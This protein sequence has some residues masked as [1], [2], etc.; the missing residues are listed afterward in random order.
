MRILLKIRSFLSYF[1]PL[2]HTVAFE[3]ECVPK[4]EEGC[5]KCDGR[6]LIEFKSYMDESRWSNFPK[7]AWWKP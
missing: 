5:E 1:W 4:S 2:E 3:C 7:F 6:G